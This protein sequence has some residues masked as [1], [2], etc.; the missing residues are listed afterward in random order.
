MLTDL[1]TLGGRNSQAN[2]LNDSGQVVGWAQTASGAIHAVLW[3]DGKAIDLGG[4]GGTMSHALSINDRGQIV[5]RSEKIVPIGNT[6]GTVW[7]RSFLWQKGTMTN[8][9][10]LRGDI[11]RALDINEHGQVAG[12]VVSNATDRAGYH[13][14]HAF[15]WQNGRM[16]DLGRG[17]AIGLNSRGEV[18]L[19]RVGGTSHAGIWR[20]GRMTDLGTLGGADSEAGAIND[21]GEVAGVSHFGKTGKN[22]LLIQHAFLWRGGKMSDVGGMSQR[23]A[24][25]GRVIALNDRGQICESFGVRSFMWQKGR[26]IDL[27]LLD[28]SVKGGYTQ[29][30][31][32]NRR[33]QI[34]G[35]SIVKN[36]NRHAF[37]W[38]NG[39]LIDLGALHGSS[40]A[41]AINDYRQIIGVSETRS[42]Q[43]HAVLW[44]LK[45]AR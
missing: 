17:S 5:G 14:E 32:M 34:V 37:F 21:Q 40:D 16:R 4:L 36:G 22:G 18:A 42:G 23:G 29:A 39:T 10:T 41:T 43:T 20:S 7:A 38:E 28:A 12:T 1:G 8:L 45:T 44:T 19:D 31:A 30:Q 27:G 25:D 11:V 26:L 33:G 2:A 24:S 15:L 9:G 3:Q 35:S 13:I 6:E